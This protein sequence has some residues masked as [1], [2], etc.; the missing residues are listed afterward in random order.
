MTTPKTAT[1]PETAAAVDPLSLSAAVVRRDGVAGTLA[2][3][4]GVPATDAPPDPARENAPESEPSPVADDVVCERVCESLSATT[5]DTVPP[6]AP[7]AAQRDGAGRFLPGNRSGAKT[8]FQ[9]GNLARVNHGFRMLDDSGKLPP[10]FQHLVADVSDFVAGCLVDEGDPDV[11]TR[12]RALLDYRARL[13]RRILQVDALIEGRGIADRRGK[14]RLAW[15]QRLE[16]LITTAQRLDMALGLARRSKPVDTLDSIARSIA[17]SRT[18]R[19]AE[20][21]TSPDDADVGPARER[22][23]TARAAVT[24]EAS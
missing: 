17:A 5:P 6:V 23:P 14:L 15:L 3:R 18:E 20:A 9:P 2:G 22:V 10:E 19:P 11:P 24:P 21:T 13:H 12:R 4:P 8:L 7:D 16:G 1:T